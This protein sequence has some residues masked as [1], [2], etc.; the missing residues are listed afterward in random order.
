M[1]YPDLWAE[2]IYDGNGI[3][4]AGLFPPL[5]DGLDFSQA[6]YHQTSFRPFV[7][8]LAFD[9]KAEELAIVWMMPPGITPTGPFAH[10]VIA[11]LVHAVDGGKVT[12]VH[13]DRQDT[14]LAIASIV[15]AFKGG[16]HA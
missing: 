6:Y 10:G 15:N 2:Q 11:A 5:L 9:E 4:H 1:Y 3:H 12:M 14:L 7:T 13:G 16:A 8:K